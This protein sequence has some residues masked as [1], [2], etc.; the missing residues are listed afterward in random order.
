MSDN[1]WDVGQ[2]N[3]SRVV[4]T[5]FEGNK[6]VV[7]AVRRCRDKADHSSYS[8]Q[9]ERAD[10]ATE[11]AILGSRTMRA[12]LDWSWLPQLNGVVRPGDLEP[13]YEKRMVAALG[14]QPAA[15]IYME[16][17]EQRLDHTILGL[18]GDANGAVR[19]LRLMCDLL[20]VVVAFSRLD[21]RHNDLMLRNVMVCRCMNPIDGRMRE[22]ELRVPEAHRVE[23]PV[24]PEYEV[25]LID[26]GLSSGGAQCAQ[27]DIVSNGCR[28]QQYSGKSTSTGTV[29]PLEL[30]PNT[31]GLPRDQIDLQCL[32]HSVNWLS[33]RSAIH[34]I[35]QDWCRRHVKDVIGRGARIGGIEA[36]IARLMP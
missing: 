24:D 9:E 3:Y 17:L 23:W 19:M 8:D 30:S 22:L 16:R 34:P 10:V 2:G 20:A 13:V 18:S 25:V 33:R 26:F 29:H 32:G 27:P 35:M 4:I 12:M 28:D 31:S 11:V 5:T 6:C 36:T 14:F 7:K 1:K 21:L 15:L